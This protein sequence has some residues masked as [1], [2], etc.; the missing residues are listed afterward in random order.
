MRTR[1]LFPF[2]LITVAACCVAPDGRSQQPG[3]SQQPGGSQQTANGSQSS[4]NGQ[5]AIKTKSYDVVLAVAVHDKKGALVTNLQKSDFTLTEEGHPQTIKSLSQEPNQPFRIGL[6]IETNRAMGGAIETERKAA[7]KFID[8]LLPAQASEGKPAESNSQAFL[9]H[10]DREVELLQDFTD[11]RDKLHQEIGDM[12]STRAAHNDTQGPETTG[13]DRSDRVHGSR[14]GNQLYDSIFLASTEVLGPK[15]GRNVLILFADGVD[16][17]SKVR[18]NEALDAAEKAHAQI[19]TVYFKGEQER[20]SFDVPDR[21]SRRGGG[22]P[23]GGGGYPGGGG[24]YPSG[25]GRRGGGGPSDTGVDGKKIM[26]QIAERTGGHAYEA[27]KKDD[28]DPIYALI[29]QELRGQ[30]VLTYTPDKPDFEG[31]FHK[32]VLKPNKEEYSVSIP[33]GYFAPGGE[34]G[35]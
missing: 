26:Q 35:R 7:D 29:G 21:N 24:G 22:W 23:G 13:E 30:Y 31:G 3:H 27:R 19:F 9:I 10:F 17:G 25:G 28:L 6:L 33:E 15:Q 4:E 8:T 12:G 5:P 1:I 18:L 11:S 16:R 34:N 20:Q 2:A 32:V 14:G